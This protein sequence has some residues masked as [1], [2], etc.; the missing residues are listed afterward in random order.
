MKKLIMSLV[1]LCSF[2]VVNAQ[3]TSWMEKNFSLSGE[4]RTGSSYASLFGAKLSDDWSLFYMLDIQH[5][6]GFGI[7]MYRFTDF[8]EEGL[9]RLSFF[10]AYWSGTLSKTVSLYAA[11]EYGFF[12]NDRGLD[13]LC[14]YAMLFWDAKVVNVTL[15]S[16]YSYYLKTE[17]HEFIMKGQLSKEIINGTILE[18]SGWYHSELQKHFFWSI[19][20]NQ[21]LL[22][23]FYLQLDYLQKEGTSNFLAG[24]GYKF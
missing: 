4:I 19:G 15:A 17:P 11:M 1:V 12:D 9:G 6:S 24:V 18:L 7:G 5:K 21:K 2:V 3:E 22:K 20:V 10:D 23:N 8:Q 13:F 16:M 14:P